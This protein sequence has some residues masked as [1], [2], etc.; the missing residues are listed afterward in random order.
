MMIIRNQVQTP[1][2]HNIAKENA[3]SEALSLK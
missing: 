1:R 2:L 3:T